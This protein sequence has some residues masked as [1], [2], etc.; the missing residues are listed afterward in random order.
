MLF[1]FV[2]LSSSLI[3]REHTDA[4]AALA[5]NIT[6][7]YNGDTLVATKAAIIPYNLLIKI[8]KNIDITSNVP[9]TDDN[10]TIIPLDMTSGAG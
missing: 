3:K 2:I 4:T 5:K 8:N 7:Q 6:I 9:N 10:K 1:F